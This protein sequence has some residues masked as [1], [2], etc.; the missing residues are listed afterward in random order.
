MC[1]TDANSGL[2]VNKTGM[3]TQYTPNDIFELTM[4]NFAILEFLLILF[5]IQ[6]IKIQRATLEK[7]IKINSYPKW[8]GLAE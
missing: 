6:W 3:W 2:M 1:G 5:P 8:I 7:G 4:I